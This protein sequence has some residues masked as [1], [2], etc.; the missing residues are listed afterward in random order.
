MSSAAAALRLLRLSR[1]HRY[2][3]PGADR[4]HDRARAEALHKVP[5]ALSLHRHPDPD[6][7]QRPHPQLAVEERYGGDNT[8]H[9]VNLSEASSSLR[10]GNSAGATTPYPKS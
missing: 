9:R 1:A 3:E 2:L 6:G 7:L 10:N 4:Q 8:D 5:R